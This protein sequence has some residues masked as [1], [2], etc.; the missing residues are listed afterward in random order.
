LENFERVLRLVEGG[1]A[2]LIAARRTTE[3]LAE[4]LATLRARLI[5]G[6]APAAAATELDALI[7]ELRGELAEEPDDGAGQTG[8]RLAPAVEGT[9]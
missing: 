9:D 3:D 2:R 1:W 8:G 6:A 4:R 7:A 5:S